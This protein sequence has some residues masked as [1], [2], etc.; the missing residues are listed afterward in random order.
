MKGSITASCGCTL[1]DDEELVTVFYADEVCD[2][3]EGFKP[4][5]AIGAW[6]PTCEKNG[7]ERGDLFAN[8]GE[9][10]AW[11]TAAYDAHRERQ[12]LRNG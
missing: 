7:R 2:I 1:K 10:D 12:M 3:E 9:G 5:L 6:C 11:L 8:E 4:A